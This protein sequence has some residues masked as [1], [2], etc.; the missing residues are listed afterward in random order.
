MPPIVTVT[1]SID[2]LPLPAVITS[3]P[4]CVAGAPICWIVQ[5]DGTF[6]DGSDGRLRS[7]AST[8]IFESLH[9]TT[10]AVTPAIVTEP[11]PCDAPKP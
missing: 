1:A 5:V 6:S 4:H 10:G 11:L 3:S 2:R 7:G 8:T 9:D